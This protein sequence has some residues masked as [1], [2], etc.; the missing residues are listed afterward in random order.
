MAGSDSRE[1]KWTGGRPRNEHRRR[2]K[3][4]EVTRRGKNGR[5]IRTGKTGG[6]IEMGKNG[7]VRGGMKCDTATCEI[8]CAVKEKR[9]IP[10]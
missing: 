10:A 2:E 3:N 7:K 4:G 1:M 9:E 5:M 6:V 8:S